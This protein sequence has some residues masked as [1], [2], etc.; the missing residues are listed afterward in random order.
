[1]SNLK[2]S[3]SVFKTVESDRKKKEPVGEVKEENN[4]EGA[5]KVRRKAPAGIPSKTAFSQSLKTPVVASKTPPTEEQE[6]VIE[7][8]AGIV[9]VKAFAGAGKT[10]TLT[11]YAKRRSRG[12]GLYLAFNRDIKEEALSKFPPNV[13]CMTSHG[14]AF[15]QFGKNISH[16]L[17]GYI[18]WDMIYNG[19]GVKPHFGN[20]KN[21]S[22][23]YSKLLQETVG[24]FIASD[25]EMIQIEHVPLKSLMMLKNNPKIFS[26]VP[27]Y[28]RYSSRC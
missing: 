9:K 17:N 8:E 18:Q 10:F 22:R 24:N 2:E 19:A 27:G 7:C 21:A 5:Y 4:Q 3:L 16:K 23:M 26:F 15:P 28:H 25:Q 6:K 12:R 11:E 14:L 1:M 13:K 20:N